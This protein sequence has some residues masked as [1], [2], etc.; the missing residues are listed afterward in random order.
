MSILAIV[1]LAA[2][3]LGIAFAIFIVWKAMS[4]TRAD[5][6]RPRNT[7]QFYI[8][9]TGCQRPTHQ[10]AITDRLCPECVANIDPIAA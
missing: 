3:A 9:C 2:A 8:T 7:V 1:I 6:A 4:N 10:S 5:E